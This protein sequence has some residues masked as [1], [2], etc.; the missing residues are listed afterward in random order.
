[1]MTPGWYPSPHFPGMMQYWSGTE[2]TPRLSSPDSI[3]TTH[4]ERASQVASESMHGESQIPAT[5]G[6]IIGG[7][8]TGVGLLALLIITLFAG[9]AIVG[10]AQ[11]NGAPTAIGTVTDLRAW[12]DSPGGEKSLG[13]PGA[14]APEASFTVDGVE[15]AAHTR[16]FSSPCPWRVGQTISV[17]YLPVD[18]T[19]SAAFTGEKQFSGWMLMPIAGIVLTLPGAWM[20]IASLRLLRGRRRRVLP[21]LTVPSMGAA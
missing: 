15:Y 2:W 21:E 10:F 4:D 19:Q 9:P 7:I 3:P 17:T 18:I 1:M 16:S 14:C 20:F 5:I 11:Y 8:W 6:M 13:M 12:E